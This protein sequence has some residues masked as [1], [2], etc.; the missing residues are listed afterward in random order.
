MTVTLLNIDPR[1]E[2]KMSY[3]EDSTL[4]IQ[5]EYEIETSGAGTIA[6]G[7]YRV[8]V[9]RTRK[10]TRAEE[11]AWLIEQVTPYLN[12]NFLVYEDERGRNSL[13]QKC[14]GNIVKSIECDPARKFATKHLDSI[15]QTLP[16]KTVQTL[17]ES[18]IDRAPSIKELPPLFT[19]DKTELAFG[20]LTHEIKE[21]ETPLFDDFIERCG[22]NGEAVKAF[23]WA[24]LDS[25]IKLQQYLWLYGEGGDGKGSF[26]RLLNRIVGDDSY[27]GLNAKDPHWPAM[28]VGKRIAA[29]NDATNT[30]VQLSSV[31]KQVTGG[32]KVGVTQKFEKAVSAALNT[33]FI[34]TT[35]EQISI[36]DN[37]SDRR[38]A[39]YVEVAPST[40]T[41]ENYEESLFSEV[42]GILFKAQK[43]FEENYQKVTKHIL[44]DQSALEDKIEDNEVEF[45]SV[46]ED[47]FQYEE[48]SSLKKTEV[49]KKIQKH[50][51]NT[52][53]QK[54]FKEYMKKK[55]GITEAKQRVQGVQVGI[56]KNI[57][58]KPFM[59]PA[60]P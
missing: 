18:W 36:L 54:R 34:F 40:R 46:F 9:Q 24:A 57:S 56:Y 23:I 13:L 42:S 39:I 32:D 8:Q 49:Y 29:F 11:F 53:Q 3:K 20:R 15:G 60:Q 22:P 58:L 50:F 30:S 21:M 59:V 5:Q 19:L 26:C 6:H 43:A 28:C 37:K 41:F 51:L 44:N 47:Y 16:S 12:E 31:F 27:T 1:K 25:K 4:K 55:Y 52:H 2:S 45:E 48:G 14:S 17:I 38:R 35:N 7:P 33:L 10:P